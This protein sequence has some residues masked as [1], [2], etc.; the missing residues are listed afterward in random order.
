MEQ[1]YKLGDKVFVDFALGRDKGEIMKAEIRG[2]WRR[3]EQVYYWVRSTTSL[4]TDLV[5]Q[6]FIE[7]ESREEHKSSKDRQ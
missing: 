1:L 2:P 3:E 7:A 5:H 4:K 6:D